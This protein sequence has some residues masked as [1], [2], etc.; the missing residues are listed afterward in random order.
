MINMKVCDNGIVREMTAE[1]IA[2]LQPH[3]IDVP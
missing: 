3:Q 1:E 2:E